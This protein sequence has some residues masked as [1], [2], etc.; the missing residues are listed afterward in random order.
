ML[1]A[2]G[3]QRGVGR[4]GWERVVES[5]REGD[6]KTGK[7]AIVREMWRR[8]WTGSECLWVRC[9]PLK[10]WHQPDVTA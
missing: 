6:E 4:P 8:K 9:A 5:L 1:S 3:T 10:G 7:R 2:E